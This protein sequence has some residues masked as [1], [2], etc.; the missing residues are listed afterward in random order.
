M[1]YLTSSSMQGRDGLL[2]IEYDIEVNDEH[3]VLHDIMLH[4]VTVRY[5]VRIFRYRVLHDIV[6]LLMSCNYDIVFYTT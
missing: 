1:C 3:R 4:D 5:H 2:N 6:F